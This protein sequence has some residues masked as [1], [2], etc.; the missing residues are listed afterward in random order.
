EDTLPAVVAIVTTRNVRSIFGTYQT[1]GGGSG[2]VVDGRG[3]IVTNR[4]VVEDEDA[5]YVVVTN[6]GNKYEAE[7]VARDPLADLALLKVSAT[8]LPVVELG[9]SDSLRLGQNV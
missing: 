2:F 7:V 6:D 8:A 3:L 1:T 4:H 9:D 5:N